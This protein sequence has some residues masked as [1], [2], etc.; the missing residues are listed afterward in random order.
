MKR[1]ILAATTGAL[2]LTA[3]ACGS[4]TDAG[5][6]AAA[7]AATKAAAAAPSPSVDYSADTSK[8]CDAVV[9]LLS[10]KK[11]EAFGE[12]LGERIGYTT[13]KQTSAAKKAEAAAGVNLKAVAKSLTDL[14]AKAKDPKINT[15]GREVQ[16]RMDAAAED[17]TFFAKFKTVKDVDSKLEPEMNKWVE[18]LA[19]PCNLS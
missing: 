14:T 6:E 11:M 3:T 19:E 2:L 7:P 18:P 12:K 17:E 10:G 16:K 15:A 1:V 8:T 4:S 5:T 9:A 13:A